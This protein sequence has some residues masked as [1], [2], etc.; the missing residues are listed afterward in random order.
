MFTRSAPK[1][2][3]RP[4][5]AL[6]RGLALLG[7]FLAGMVILAVPA[8]AHQRTQFGSASA[9][10][11]TL[12]DRGHPGGGGRPGGRPG[13]PGRPG[14][15]GGPGGA[16]VSPTISPAAAQIRYTTDPFHTP[17]DSGNFCA[18]VWDPTLP[19]G[20]YKVFDLFAC[21]QYHLYNWFAGPSGGFYNNA[22]VDNVRVT[23][24]D[25][26]QNVIRSFTA[27]GVGT[28]D[29]TPVEWIRNC[30]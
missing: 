16:A 7:V 24:Y 5:L 15:G 1:P 23:F 3:V 17:C 6:T 10:R 18:M 25:V 28:Q 9:S 22:Q 8:S 26:G 27:T 13:R 4:L 11:V 30:G 21:H 12:A 14:G 19:F 29:W 20:G 2:G